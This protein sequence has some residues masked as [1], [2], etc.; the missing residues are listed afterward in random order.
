MKRMQTLKENEKITLSL[1]PRQNVFVCEVN[2]QLEIEIIKNQQ[3][4]NM[5]F[6]I[7]RA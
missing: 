7:L 5:A 3:K 1:L 4:I 2:Q 6:H